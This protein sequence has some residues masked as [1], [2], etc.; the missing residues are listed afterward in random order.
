LR[1]FSRFR[2]RVLPIYCDPP[3]EQC[4]RR[5]FSYAFDDQV[6]ATNGG[7]VPLL[8]F[9]PID[10][11]SVV[12][13]GVEVVPIPLM[14]GRMDVLG[15]RFGPLAYCTDVNEIPEESWPLLEGVEILILDALRFEPHP[16]HLHFDGA[17]EVI[18]RLK[19]R[20]SYLTHI[21]CRLDPEEAEKRLP[22]GVQLAYD[23]LTLD[24]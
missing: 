24:F 21:S 4:I 19:P 11:P 15:F 7:Y 3:T 13:Q 1:V 5:V 6:R 14:H 17:L 10:R 18:D 20:R 8:E 22:P 16:T 9:R 12:V 23:G 2:D